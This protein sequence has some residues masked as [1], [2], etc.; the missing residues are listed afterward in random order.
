[1]N[2]PSSALDALPRFASVER[3]IE[4]LKPVELGLCRSPRKMPSSAARQ[5]LDGFPAT[6]LRRQGQS[7]SHRRHPASVAAGIRHFDTASLG[8][9]EIV[10]NLFPEAICHFM[11]PVRLP[12][13]ASRR[14]SRN[15]AS[16]ISWWIAIPNW[17][18][19]WP[20]RAI[21]AP[22]RPSF[23][24]AAG[25]TGRRAAG[26]VQQ[27]RHPPR[28]SGQAAEAGAGLWR[29]AVP[30]LPCRLAMPGLSPFSYAQAIEIA[31]RLPS[32]CREWRS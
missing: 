14:R 31:Q 28:R 30:D 18:R 13:Q 8:E 1:M 7:A 20:K 19:F 3:A 15:M 23:R 25:A 22:S 27:I 12:G 10:K 26:D 2:A 9:I 24:L 5:F 16:P 32:P 17:M 4:G 11:A 21:P 6:S 29:R